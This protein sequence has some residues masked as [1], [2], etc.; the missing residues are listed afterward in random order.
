MIVWFVTVIVS[1]CFVFSL[2]IEMEK[3]TENVEP[4][5]RWGYLIYVV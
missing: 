4:I 3:G 5:G 2:G 1:K